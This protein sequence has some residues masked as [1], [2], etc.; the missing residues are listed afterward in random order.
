MKTK[1][2]R[3]SKLSRQ[4]A[5]AA[6]DT[7][8]DWDQLKTIFLD[9]AKQGII[10]S[11][12]QLSSIAMKKKFRINHDK[13]SK[14][15]RYFTYLARFDIPKRTS[16]YMSTSILKFGSLFCDIGYMPISYKKYNNNYYSFI[17]AKEVVSGQIAAVPIKNKSMKE[18]FNGLK[19][20]LDQGS[21]RQCHTLLWDSEAAVKS[22]KMQSLLQKELGVRCFFLTQRHKS[23]LAENAIRMIKTALAMKI[24]ASDNKTWVGPILSNVVKNY[25]SQKVGNTRFIRSSIN[26]RNTIPFLQEHLSMKNPT[27]LFNSTTMSKITNP[28]WSGILFKFDIGDK[29]LISKKITSNEDT[30]ITQTWG[31]KEE[32]AD[33]SFKMFKRQRKFWEPKSS[34]AGHFSKRQYTITGRKLKSSNKGY[35]TKVYTL[36]ELPNKF[37]YELYV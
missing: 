28:I 23:Y 7:A 21:L 15:R 30:G 2:K 27:L 34:L 10:L 22:A 32:K 18:I 20:I 19:S 3:N 29:V 33:P 37:F 35:W 1:K 8:N 4:A 5:A 9:N 26:R 13:I 14:I 25:N 17:A 24:A 16:K 12:K 36:R 11:K 31:S 6:A